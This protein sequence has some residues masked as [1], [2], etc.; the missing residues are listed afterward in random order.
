M[1]PDLER[2]IRLQEY[3]TFAEDA[4]RKIADCPLHVQ[5]LERRLE[6]ARAAVAAAR[7]R[8]T[9]SQTTRRADEKD[10]ALVQSR[11]AKFKD[12]LMEVKTNREYQAMLHEIQVAQTEIRTRED[13]LLE[14]MIEAD[15]LTAAVKRAEG[16]LAAVEREVAAERQA[17]DQ[18]V[19]TLDV[20][21]TRT[22]ADRQ[23]LIGEIDPSALAIFEQVARGRKGIA[24]AQARGGLCMICHVRLRPQVYNEV[25]RN[26]SI[27]QCD[28]CQRILYFVPEPVAG[29]SAPA[30]EG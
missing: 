7:Q 18:E 11:L 6:A 23:S 10:V 22:A 4:R 8:L 20:E 26:D 25:R 3:E 12:Q 16:E 15:D 14:I 29:A 17:L 13:R 28:T 2:L 19:K 5:A 21:L 9:E 24:V 1:H 27:I 30:V